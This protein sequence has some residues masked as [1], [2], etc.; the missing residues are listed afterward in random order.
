MTTIAAFPID[1]VGHLNPM[2]ALC[3]ALAR[4]PSVTAVRGFGRGEL[5]GLFRGVGAGFSVTMCE[6]QDGPAGDLGWKSFVRPLTHAAETLRAVQ[7]FAPDVV[8]FDPFAVLGALAARTTGAAS[9]ALVSMAGYGALGEDFVQRYG[10]NRRAL[11]R[12]NAIYARRFGVN[13]RADGALPVLYP[14]ADLT[15]VTT[16][17]SMTVPINPATQPRLTKLV[18]NAARTVHVG[19]CTGAEHLMEDVIRTLHSIGEKGPA[20]PFP[21][22]RLAEAKRRSRRVVLFSIGTVLTDFRFESP[23][24]GAPSGKSFLTNVLRAVAAAVRDDPNILLVAATGHRFCSHAEIDWPVDAIV[25][26]TVPQQ[27]ILERFADVFITHHGANSQAESILAG[28]PMVSL[29]G[30]GDQLP[31]ARMALARGLA[32]SLWELENPFGTCDAHLMREAIRLAL[33]DGACRRASAEVAAEM[34]AA[35]GAAEAARQIKDL[36]NQI[37]SGSRE[38]GLMVRQG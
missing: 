33:E 19:P 8:L 15:I 28:V 3:G 13:F 27:E 7:D 36:V 11:L 12:A 29:P 30:V 20:A 31:N 22:E 25:L 1:A 32:V 2:I 21:F 16:V 9:A 18:G 17:E 23:V 37:T 5:E 26:A 10:W 4:E 34:R 24:G 38:A 6:V 14:A 35:G